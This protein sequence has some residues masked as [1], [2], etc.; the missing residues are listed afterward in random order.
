MSEGYH[1]EP[2]NP[3]GQRPAN[4]ALGA[5]IRDMMSYLPVHEKTPVRRYAVG[6][7]EKPVRSVRLDRVGRCF[8]KVS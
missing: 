8:A 2:H 3:E 1:F 4:K 6:D 7:H 5:L